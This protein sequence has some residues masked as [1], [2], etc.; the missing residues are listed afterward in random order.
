MYIE[1]IITDLGNKKNKE[2]DR[3]NS[4]GVEDEVSLWDFVIITKVY[5]I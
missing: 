2:V 5:Y 1:F 4:M 3:P